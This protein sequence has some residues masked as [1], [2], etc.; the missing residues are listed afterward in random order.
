VARTPWFGQQ[1]PAINL[2]HLARRGEEV[3]ER[4]ARA[5]VT[6]PP[7]N[8]IARAI[9]RLDTLNEELRAGRFPAETDF[10]TQRLILEHQSTLLDA[11]LVVFALDE[12]KVGPRAIK[13]VHLSALLEGADLPLS[14]GHDRSRD[15]QFEAVVGASL[16]LAGLQ[17]QFGEPDFH[18]AFYDSE[19]GVAVKRISSAKPTKV[20]DRLREANQQLRANALQGIAVVNLDAWPSDLEPAESADSFGARFEEDCYEAYRQLMKL[21]ERPNLIGVIIS[22]TNCGWDFGA[23]PPQPWR[24]SGWQIILFADDEREKSRLI[25]FF[26]PAFSRLQASR[27]EIARLLARSDAASPST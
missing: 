5:G 20:Y 3:L 15:F 16:A 2:N 1:H 8:R 18:V 17:V 24:Q 6:V 12:R 21:S 10:A 23:S 26:D 4:I 22:R 11:L 25:S 13:E 14:E 19:I 27:G 7:G 9:S